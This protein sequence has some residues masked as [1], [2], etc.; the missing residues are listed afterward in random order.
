MLDNNETM[1]RSGT[2]TRSH[3]DIGI[4]DFGGFGCTAGADALG[5]RVSA[6]G[7]I[8]K[9]AWSSKRFAT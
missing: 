6:C 3:P 9:D 1:S 4:D 8:P 7:L 2:E 5:G